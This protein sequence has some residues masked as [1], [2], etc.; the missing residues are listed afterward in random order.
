MALYEV[1]ALWRNRGKNGEEFFSGNI[2]A[3]G[4]V[5]IFRNKNKSGARQPDFKV[6]QA[7][8]ATP[9]RPAFSQ[10][11]TRDIFPFDLGPDGQL[12]EVN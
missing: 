3:K 4:K 1:G 12:P 8:G 2:S 11:E 10:P 7:D 9:D 6:M 5:L